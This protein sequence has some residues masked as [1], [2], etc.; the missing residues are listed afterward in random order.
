[1]K[2]VHVPT[3]NVK[4]SPSTKVT[5]THMFKSLAEQEPAI[6]KTP[7]TIYMSFKKILDG[8]EM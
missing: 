3:T 6:E 1:M 4:R 8:A 5:L 7:K 2:V